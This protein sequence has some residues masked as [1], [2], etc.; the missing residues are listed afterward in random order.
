MVPHS[1]VDFPARDGG[2]DDPGSTTACLQKAKQ[3]PGAAGDCLGGPVQAGKLQ[4]AGPQFGYSLTVGSQ[5]GEV[6]SS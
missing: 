5:A 4:R 2:W 3:R 1:L 6:V